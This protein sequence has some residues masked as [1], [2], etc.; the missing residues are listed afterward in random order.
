MSITPKPGK[1]YALGA[2]FWAVQVTKVDA[3]WVHIRLRPDADPD[4]PRRIKRR[5]WAGKDPVALTG[6]LIQEIQNRAAAQREAAEKGIVLQPVAIGSGL[7]SRGKAILAAIS[8][9]A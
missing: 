1:L 9:L 4:I 3:T 2:P 6:E 8:G 5:H 7:G